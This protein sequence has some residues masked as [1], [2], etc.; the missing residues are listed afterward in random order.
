MDNYFNLERVKQAHG[1]AETITAYNR[2][3]REY[4]LHREA[5]K[6]KKSELGSTEL[7]LLMILA[8]KFGR[9]DEVD[10][11]K[12]AIGIVN[13]CRAK[14]ETLERESLL[15]R[16]AIGK[17]LG[18]LIEAGF[19]TQTYERGLSGELTKEGERRQAV[20]LSL[21]NPD[22]NNYQR[23]TIGAPR[24]DGSTNGQWKHCVYH[25]VPAVWDGVVFDSREVRVAPAA[26][27]APV[28]AE[29]QDVDSIDLP[30]AAKA[31][32]SAGVTK[33]Q[34]DE[35][36]ED[37]IKHY[38]AGHSTLNQDGDKPRNSLRGACKELARRA[39]DLGD[40]NYANNFIWWMIQ[41][42]NAEY[43]RLMEKVEF[44]GGPYGLQ[45]SIADL[46]DEF[47]PE[48]DDDYGQNGSNDDS[49]EAA[50]DESEYAVPDLDHDEDAGFPPTS[51]A[52]AATPVFEYEEEVEPVEEVK[53]KP[54]DQY[55][56][57]RQAFVK[58]LL[59][60]TN[61]LR[62]PSE[63]FTIELDSAQGVLIGWQAKWLDSVPY[64]RQ[65]VQE[66]VSQYILRVTLAWNVAR[67]IAEHA[68]QFAEDGKID[69]NYQPVVD[70]AVLAEIEAEKA[71]ADEL[72][73]KQ[74][75]EA[76]ERARKQREE[77]E[78][79]EIQR[80]AD[81][82][83]AEAARKVKLRERN[84]RYVL[85]ENTDE[86]GVFI[87][88]PKKPENIPLVREYLTSTFPNTFTVTDQTTSMLQGIVAAPLLEALKSD[89][90]GFRDNGYVETDADRE[91]AAAA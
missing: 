91:L 11:K 33:K 47:V 66:R 65:I 38:F 52:K 74:K 24:K 64:G 6:P 63:G 17:A 54:V 37:I 15:E 68:E 48:K 87:L 84:C 78:A 59:K 82:A 9:I 55:K 12:V 61:L 73:R 35:V 18:K 49:D 39:L 81:A 45:K 80:K 53:P 86:D 67:Y 41:R 23:R 72:A 43:V 13:G 19:I 3:I 16:K 7:T 30:V 1:L 46:W 36:F 44:L 60:E 32:A 58:A 21:D 28:S 77:A 2:T 20:G 56:D 14:L 22:K 10:G 76:G 85:V 51:V 75:E 62:R 83:V 79:A 50:N 25:L 34:T 5:R 90:I 26:P 70:P 40:L 57:H 42:R 89:P 69:Q 8:R 4:N 31:K 27:A 29:D 71:A 88:V